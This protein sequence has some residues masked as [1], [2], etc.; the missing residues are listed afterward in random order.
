MNEP[1][2]YQCMRAV[3]SLCTCR[4]CNGANHQQGIPQ[5]EGDVV[6]ARRRLARLMREVESWDRRG[7]P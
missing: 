6:E 1:C 4:M 3:S 2:Y 5:Q 7:K